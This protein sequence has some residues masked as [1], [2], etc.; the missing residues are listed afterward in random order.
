V[1]TLGRLA[2]AV[3]NRLGRRA[4]R[5][6]HDAREIAV[7]TYAN[8]RGRGLAEPVVVFESDD[9]GATRLRDAASRCVLAA[10]GIDVDS[11]A[12]DRVDTLESREDLDRLFCVL[13]SHRDEHG[14]APAFTANVVMGNP[15]FETIEREDFSR[16]S[17]EPVW[18]SYERAHGESLRDV[19]REGI[20]AGVCLPQLHGREHVHVPLWL[21]D[22]RGG[23]RQTRAAFDAG[24][25]AHNTATGSRFRRNYLACCWAES[26]DDI[27]YAE[28]AIEEGLDLFESA[29]GYRSDSFVACNYVLPEALEPVLARRRV[30]H[31]QTQRAHLAPRGRYERPRVKRR[32]TGQ[33]NADGQTFGVRNVS[34]E[35]FEAQGDASLDG[36]LAAIKRAFRLRR[37]AIVCSHR[38]NYV[39]GIS[40]HN[41]DR[42][43]RSL[44]QLL[45]AILREWPA[46]RFITTPELAALL[47]A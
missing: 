7:E 2:G 10:H 3:S 18:R 37:P 24:Y 13:A 4:K 16:Y 36:A 23:H 46:V 28:K 44:D 19:W 45:A 35:P 9:W 32:F 8:A 29:F 14:R 33:T 17:H 42:S 21:R 38:A 22:L 41:R 6:R 31:I 26:E 11:S 20:D 43:L 47:R 12:Y 39:G 15:D 5:A 1:T 27:A 25:F 40:A 34:F 30:R